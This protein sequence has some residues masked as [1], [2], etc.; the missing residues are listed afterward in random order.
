MNA[1]PASTCHIPHNGVAGH[2]LTTLG[3]PD[4]HPVDALDAD[5]LGGTADLVDQPVERTRLRAFGG[6]VR[7]GIQLLQYLRD[8]DVAL[9][10]RRDQVIQVLQVERLGHFQ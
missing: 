3:V 7:L 2:R 4:H 8:I 5:A 9:T 1:H 6:A 10:N